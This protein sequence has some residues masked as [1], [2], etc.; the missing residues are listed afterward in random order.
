M[1]YDSRT[2]TSGLHKE[3]T[4]PISFLDFSWKSHP[5]VLTSCR[6][7]YILRWGGH[8]KGIRFLADKKRRKSR[9]S[10]RNESIRDNKIKYT[11]VSG[12]LSHDHISPDVINALVIAVSLTI[13][14]SWMCQCCTS[15]LP[16]SSSSFLQYS[17]C[18]MD[19]FQILLFT[20]FLPN[21]HHFPDASPHPHPPAVFS[22]SPS[23][24]PVS[25]FLQRD[26]L[27]APIFPVE[28][29]HS[30]RYTALH[31]LEFGI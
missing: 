30:P 28:N 23:L 1:K 25:H 2:A 13:K 5:Y 16:R 21:L 22:S 11:L 7:S 19:P 27:G 3:R 24:P 4:H 14:L 10:L 31:Q 26:S 8:S 15:R 12:P 18:P 17:F 6:S 29:A 20:P 9:S